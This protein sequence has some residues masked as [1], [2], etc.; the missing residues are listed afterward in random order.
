MTRLPPIYENL[1]IPN[2]STFPLEPPVKIDL[3]LALQIRED[4]IDRA[5]H[6]S[7]F[8]SERLLEN[9]VRE[10]MVATE[11]LKQQPPVMK[12]G[13]TRRSIQ[14]SRWEQLELVTDIVKDLLRLP[15]QTIPEI[16]L[17]IVEYIFRCTIPIHENPLS[18]TLIC[19]EVQLW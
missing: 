16:P 10:C 17:D 13:S 8:F 5:T 12:P 6:R 15:V 3:D 7:A 14:Q 9:V 18:F 19:Q 1:V 11:Y 4:Y 2:Q